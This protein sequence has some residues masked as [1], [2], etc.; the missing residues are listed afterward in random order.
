MPRPKRRAAEAFPEEMDVDV[1]HPD[2]ITDEDTQ[3]PAVDEEKAEAIW[4]AVREE[5][6]ESENP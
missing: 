3:K 2:G 4:S 6:H 1:P 5:Y